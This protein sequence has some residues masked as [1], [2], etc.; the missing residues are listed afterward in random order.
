MLYFESQFLKQ[1]YNFAVKIY[2]R[3]HLPFSPPHPHLHPRLF[4]KTMLLPFLKSFAK[5][6]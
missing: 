5:F 1:W 3:L 6:T 2:P 4:G